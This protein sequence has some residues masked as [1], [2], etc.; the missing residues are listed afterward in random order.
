[1][2]WILVTSGL[3]QGSVLGP[4]VFIMYSYINY[5]DVGLN[6][7]TLKF[8][9]DTKIGH[10]IFDDSDRLSL[11]EDLRKISEMSERWEMHFNVNKCHILQE[12]T[13]NQKFEFEMNGVKLDSVKYA[14]YLGVTIASNLSSPG[15]AKV[16]RVK[17]TECW[18][19]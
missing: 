16:P 6:N 12:G 19:L 7:F 1:M 3:P 8:A 17:T 11:R 13:R 15:N 2:G 10:S 5:V 4:L 18:V 14:K 9:D